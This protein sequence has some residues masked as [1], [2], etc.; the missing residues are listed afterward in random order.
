MEK[1]MTENMLP[2]QGKC[3]QEAWAPDQNEPKHVE[4]VSF[5]LLGIFCLL[6]MLDHQDLI[7]MLRKLVRVRPR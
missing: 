3:K 4:P 6:E 2:R 7:D 1:D 5:P